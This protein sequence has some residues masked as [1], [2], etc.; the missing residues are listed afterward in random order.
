MIPHASPYRIS[1]IKANLFFCKKICETHLRI[2]EFFFEISFLFIDM[3]KW[4]VYQVQV[5]VKDCL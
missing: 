5:L 4:V 2:I 1:T 3:C